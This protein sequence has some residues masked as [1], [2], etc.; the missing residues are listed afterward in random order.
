MIQG[1]VK[2]KYATSGYLFFKPSFFLDIPVNINRPRGYMQQ[3][4]DF[5]SRASSP[6]KFGTLISSG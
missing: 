3:I 5:R 2:I 4:R 6:D 1:V